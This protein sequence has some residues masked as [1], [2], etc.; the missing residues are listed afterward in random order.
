MHFK[1][2][3]IIVTLGL[4]LISCTKT[5]TCV[6]ALGKT[7]GKVK[8]YTRNKAVSVCKSLGSTISK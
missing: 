2:F 8:S 6:D 7:T 4:L 3:I 5:Y 1:N